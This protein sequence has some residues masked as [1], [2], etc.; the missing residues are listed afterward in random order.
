M[1]NDQ[2][3]YHLSAATLRDTFWRF[4]R[5]NIARAFL[6]MSRRALALGLVY[7]M[8]PLG[9]ADMFAQDAPPPPPD[10]SQGAPQQAYNPLTP[11]QIDQLVAPIALYP[12]SLVA[13]ILAASTFPNEIADA[14]GF[15]Q[16]HPGVPPDQMGQMVNGLNWDPSVK[17]L[18]AFPTVLDNL[19]KNADWT[20]Q[21]GNAYYNQPQ[22]VMSAVQVMRQR[23]YE[24]GNLKSN[25]QLAVTYQPNNIVIAPAN[26]TVV[27]VPYY[28]PTVVYGAPVAYW[29]GYYPPPPPPGYA[30]VAGLA[31]GFGVG[32]AVASWNHWGWGWHSWGCGWGGHSTVVYNRNVYVSRSVTVVNHGYYGGYDRN[33]AARTYNANLAR[34]APNYRPGYNGTYAH[35]GVYN[36]SYNRTVSNNYNRNVT[37]NNVNRNVTNNNVNRNVTNNNVNRNNTNNNYNRGTTN[38]NYNR[39]GTSPTANNNNNRPGTNN[40]YNRPGTSPGANNNYNR[41]AT[42]TSNTNRPPTANNN[43]NRPTTTSNNNRPTTNNNYNR[44]TNT[45]NNAYHPPANN[46]ANHPNNN[47][48]PSGGSKPA[49]QNHPKSESHPNNGGKPHDK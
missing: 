21:L 39:P 36:N 34:T 48:H 5:S 16:S 41:P 32:I 22:D 12:D 27:Y 42:N 28:N 24:A 23:A 15:V 44:P 29:G 13:Q 6:G 7:L 37:N 14:D 3:T 31:I 35:S 1:E 8:I 26:P 25:Q 40:S 43:Y 45:N 4:N 30:L 38:N 10:A 17:A 46:N 33:V 9:V 49:P 20:S 19:N 2:Y 18:I 47:S 11:D